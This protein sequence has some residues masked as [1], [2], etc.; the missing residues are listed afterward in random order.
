MTKADDAGWFR[1]EKIGKFKNLVGI[2]QLPRLDAADGVVADW[3]QLTAPLSSD[4]RGLRLIDHGT[5]SLKSGIGVANWDWR[6][7]DDGFNIE[8][9]VS[10]T[11]PAGARM[12]LVE[13]ST[14][15]TTVESQMALALERVGELAVEDRFHDGNDILWVYRNICVSISN[16]GRGPKVIAVARRIQSFLVAHLV[17]DIA[18]HVPRIA[19]IEISKSPVRTGDTFEVQ[20]RLPEHLRPGDFTIDIRPASWPMLDPIEFGECSTVFHATHSGRAELDVIVLDPVT[21]LSP[22]ASVVI[23]VLP[24]P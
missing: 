6:R 23:D 11:G 12:K 18:S 21:L 5:A 17:P 1:R 4:L 15:T 9:F 2:D 16:F 7:R 22:Q 19:G 14:D 3:R 8:L 20:V 10:G 13:K 24:A